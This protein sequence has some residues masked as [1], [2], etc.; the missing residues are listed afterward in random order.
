MKKVR[1]P[2][3][4]NAEASRFKAELSRANEECDLLKEAA[5]YFAKLSG[6][7]THS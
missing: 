6:C 4:F 5:T 2:A 1:H 7:S 3:E